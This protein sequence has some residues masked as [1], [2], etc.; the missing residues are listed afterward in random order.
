MKKRRIPKRPP[1]QGSLPSA[2]LPPQPADEVIVPYLPQAP[3]PPLGKE[4]HPR[5]I[6]PPVPRGPDVPD[7]HPSPPVVIKPSDSCDTG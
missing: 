2:D 7:P 5:R 1:P 4:I 3:S 6:I